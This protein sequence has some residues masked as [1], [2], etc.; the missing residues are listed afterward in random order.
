[1]DRD[2]TA[3]APGGAHSG[4]QIRLL[5][6]DDSASMRELLSRVFRADGQFEVVGTAKDGEEAVALTARLRPDVVT[7]DL[8]LPRLNGALAT[9]RIMSETPTPVVVV[10]T[11]VHQREIGLA[12]EA[13]QAGAVTLLNKPP[14]PD[15][16]RHAHAVRELLATVRLMAGVKV[17]RRWSNGGTPAPAAAGS[18]PSQTTPVRHAPPPRHRRPVA[19]MIV[20]STGGPQAIQR[21]LQALGGNLT[22]PVLIVQHI[23]DGFAA[24]M[25]GW[26]TSSCPQTVQLAEHGDTPS[27]GMVYLAPGDRH[28]LVTRR[29][30]LA[31]SKAPPAG[32]FRPSGNLLFESGAEYYGANAVGILLTGMGEDGAAGLGALRAAGAMTI[33]QNEAT[34]VVYG[35][36]AAAVHLGAAEQVLPLPEIGPEVRRLLGLGSTQAM[37]PEGRTP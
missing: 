31:L 13:L 15:D 32:G 16:P 25:A 23:N 30:T 21:L 2:E 28:L 4:G 8:H 12:F 29:G 33:A 14:G 20:A 36:P 6:V 3:A 5:V 27:A 19:I 35:M 9:R 11:S 17:V 1:M 10:S 22:V 34:C 26:L 24:G 18:A 7:M 37:P